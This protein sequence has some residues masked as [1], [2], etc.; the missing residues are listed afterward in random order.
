MVIKKIPIIPQYEVERIRKIHHEGKAK[1]DFHNLF[2]GEYI[3]DIV[4]GAND[5]II[6]TFAVVAGVA[7]AA[8]SPTIVLILGV[9]NLFAD[10]FSMAAGNYLARK[11]EKEYKKTERQR[12]EWEIDKLPQEE[13]G[14][15]RD[16]YQAKG[17]A[18]HDLERAV[19]IIT[20]NRKVWV[21]EMMIGELKIMDDDIGHP[22]KN[23]LATFCSF[24]VAGAI[25]LI[26]YVLGLQGGLAFKWSVVATA[27]I[28]FVVGS[29]RTLI[30]GRRWWLAGL[31]MLSV[32]AVAATVAYILGYLLSQ[33]V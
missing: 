25:P 9:A 13:K 7:G 32:G 5:G 3:G 33:L 29:L 28:L 30:T 17:F 20:S 8:L 27:V 18:G 22:L 1:E 11:S 26:P 4:Y 12:E 6:T 19:K 21:D 31:E 16:I 24:A 14:E 23:S 15:I 10:G 2:A